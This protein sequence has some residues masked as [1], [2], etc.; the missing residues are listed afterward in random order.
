MMQSIEAEV[1][2]QGNIK[3]C[4][5]IEL[6]QRYRAIVTLIEPIDTFNDL[7][8]TD[9]DLETAYREANSEADSS[10]EYLIADGL[11]DETW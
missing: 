8:L 9:E 10:W 5:P 2:K 7:P 1:S 4:E 3:F 11:S 6:D